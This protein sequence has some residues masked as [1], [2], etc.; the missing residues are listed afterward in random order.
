ME[1]QHSRCLLDY[2]SCVG[3]SHHCLSVSLSLSVKYTSTKTPTHAESEIEEKVVRGRWVLV[4][5]RSPMGMNMDMWSPTLHHF[6]HQLNFLTAICYLLSD[7]EAIDRQA[8]V[9]IWYFHFLH[10][11]TYSPHTHMY[12][13]YTTT[14]VRLV[15][16]VGPTEY[17]ILLVCYT[18]STRVAC[19]VACLIN[20]RHYHRRLIATQRRPPIPNLNI[21]MKLTLVSY[22][23]LY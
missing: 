9:H 21:K 4:I 10:R 23:L 8:D 12:S 7:S 22:L 13:K 17:G 14:N 18:F 5:I 15:E 16:V 2:F 19:L 11:C 6:I 1:S 3:S 20:R